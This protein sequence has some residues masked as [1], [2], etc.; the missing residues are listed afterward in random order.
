MVTQ[1]EEVAMAL[2]AHDG[3]EEQGQVMAVAVLGVLHISVI[4]ILKSG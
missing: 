4:S 3:Q 1:R 2:A